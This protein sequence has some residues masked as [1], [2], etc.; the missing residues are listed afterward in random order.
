MKLKSR[1]SAFI[2]VK[3][4]MLRNY[5]R[6]YTQSPIIRGSNVI[7]QINIFSFDLFYFG[8]LMC[9]NVMQAGKVLMRFSQSYEQSFFL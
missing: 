2:H 4:K 3:H 1:L 5:K 7:G 9:G 6:F 8:S